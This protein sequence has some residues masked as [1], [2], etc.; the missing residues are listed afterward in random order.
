[1]GGRSL[2]RG[3]RC[4]T[5]SL[6]HKLN[7]ISSTVEYYPVHRHGHR[8]LLPNKDNTD[9]PHHLLVDKLDP[10]EGGGVG[11]VSAA[12]AKGD[13]LHPGQ[14]GAIVLGLACIMTCEDDA[15]V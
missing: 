5:Q 11:G 13:P 3:V 12:L 6:V 14:R 10:L 15:D 8:S 2:A 1:M 4:P 7:M 9:L